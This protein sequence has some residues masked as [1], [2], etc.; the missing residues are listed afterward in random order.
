MS[1]TQ[2]Q[3]LL[4]EDSSDDAELTIRSLR[5]FNFINEIIWLKDGQE[6]INYLQSSIRADNS[7]ENRVLPKLILLDLKLP[8]ISGLEVLEVIRKSDKISSIPVVV[9]TSSREDQDVQKAYELGANSY[10]VKPIDFD[11]F[12]KAARDI[13]HYWLLLNEPPRS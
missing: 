3:I 12:T 5:D 9:M 7:Q 1:A 8:K 6:A 11:Q 10:V 13:S 2:V 4:V